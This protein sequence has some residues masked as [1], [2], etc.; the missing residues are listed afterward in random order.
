MNIENGYS[1]LDCGCGSG[2]LTSEI[3][4]R[5]RK[6]AKLFGSDLTPEMI[7]RAKYRV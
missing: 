3:L 4:R 2:L 7:K 6:D 1:I 5:K